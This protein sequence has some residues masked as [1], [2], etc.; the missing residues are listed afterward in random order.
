MSGEREHARDVVS[1]CRAHPFVPLLAV[2]GLIGQAD[3]AL[4]EIDDIPARVAV[5]GVDEGVDEPAETVAGKSAQCGDD[6]LRSPCG[7]GEG[8]VVRDRTQP[9]GIDPLGVHET[10]VEVADLGCHR[11]RL[12]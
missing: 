12:G 6:V 4:L 11:A 5:I 2:V 3:A 10:G 8:Q 1:V 7:R 9:E